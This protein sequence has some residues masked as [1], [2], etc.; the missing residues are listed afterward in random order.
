MPQEAKSAREIC[1]AQ[2]LSKQ[3]K[4]ITVTGGWF[5]G[6]LC[7]VDNSLPLSLCFFFFFC[8]F[9]FFVLSVTLLS[10]LYVIFRM[11]SEVLFEQIPVA[12]L[13]RIIL[14][15]PLFEKAVV[16]LVLMYTECSL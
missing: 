4:R 14:R 10:I 2:K 8:F 9:V 6:K 12:R 15:R 3:Y 1:A 7:R 13:A 11:I 5:V 16:K